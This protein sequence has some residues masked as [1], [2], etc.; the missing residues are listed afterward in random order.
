MINMSLPTSE[1]FERFL[2]FSR[3]PSDLQRRDH[4]QLCASCA[5]KRDAG[6]GNGR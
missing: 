4:A 2:E 1:Q 6:G 5:L 3:R